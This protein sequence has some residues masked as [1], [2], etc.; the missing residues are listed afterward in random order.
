MG[1]VEYAHEQLSVLSE[2]RAYFSS[3]T[4]DGGSVGAFLDKIRLARYVSAVF[5]Y[6][7]AGVL[8][9]R[10]R[11]YIRADLHGFNALDELAVAVIDKDYRIGHA[12]DGLC[13]LGY[14]L[15]REAR[16]QGIAART[17][18][19]YY[20]WLFCLHRLGYRGDIGLTVRIEVN[21]LVLHAEVSERAHALAFY[22]D[23]GMNR[24]IGL[25]RGAEHCIA[26]AQKPEESN[27]ERM[28]AA[29]EAVTHERRLGAECACKNLIERLASS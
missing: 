26:G 11:H 19:I 22:A 10:T 23:N 12:L 25:P 15:D 18:D 7:A 27:A 21:L 5:G 14:L 17:L 6:S 24:V 29:G 20:L 4:G 1:R 13:N 2:R 3:E 9:Q 8:Y 28:C 16:A